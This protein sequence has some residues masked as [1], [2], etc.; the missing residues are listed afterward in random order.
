MASHEKLENALLQSTAF[1]H[2]VLVQV[3]ICVADCL[4]LRK[5]IEC[6]SKQRV[7]TPAVLSLACPRV[8]WVCFFES[9]GVVHYS[10]LSLA[11]DHHYNLL[12]CLD[13]LQNEKHCRGNMCVSSIFT[14]LLFFSFHT[15][16]FSRSIQRLLRTH[17][18]FEFTWVSQT[19]DHRQILVLTLP[20]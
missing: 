4:R 5:E 9:N 6:F 12:A 2:L 18:S 16:V 19:Y 13:R 7:D 3:L 8:I 17:S 10:I 20:Y 15:F 1:V 11:R 14:V